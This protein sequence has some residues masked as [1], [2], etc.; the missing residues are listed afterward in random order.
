VI[1]QAAGAITEGRDAV[2]QLRSSQV[3]AGELPL[4]VRTLG[5][6]LAADAANRGSAVFQVEV[7]GERAASIQSSGTR[8]IG[9]AGEA[10]RNAFR[11]AQR[12]G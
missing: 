2:Q 11:H 5:E 7:E 6:E 3:D 9:F 1:E 10:L 8:F 12:T 4:A